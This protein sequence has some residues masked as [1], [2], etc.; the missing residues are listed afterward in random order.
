MLYT[1]ESF[2][3]AQ[4]KDTKRALSVRI[5][6]NPDEDPSCRGHLPLSPLQRLQVD[7]H[8]VQQLFFPIATWGHSRKLKVYD[9]TRLRINRSKHEIAVTCNKTAMLLKH[10]PSPEIQQRAQRSIQKQLFWLGVLGHKIPN[11]ILSLLRW[12]Y[13]PHP[14]GRLGLIFL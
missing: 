7:R 13:T 14:A 2:C 3:R 9:L 1:E 4:G 5:H 12:R 6:V 8:C 11:K 10:Y